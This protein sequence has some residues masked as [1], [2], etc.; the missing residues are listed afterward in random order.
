MGDWWRDV[1]SPKTNLWGEA[2]FRWLLVGLA[3]LGSL[4]IVFPNTGSKSSREPN[5]AVEQRG[6]WE[7][8]LTGME[9]RLAETLASIEGAGRVRVKLTAASPEACT[10]LMN[11]EMDTKK[12]EEQNDKKVIRRDVEE[13]VKRDLALANGSP[14]LLE[15][16]GP[17]ITGALVVAEGACD[18][19]VCE[20]LQR[21]VASLLNLAPSKITVLPMSKGGSS[22]GN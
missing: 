10:Y 5:T 22:D 6:G 11:E 18:P 9:E 8:S 17:E 19:H 4:L 21:A 16:K 12:T 1:K 3:L 14:V 2:R 15:R 7:E 13:R 20:Q